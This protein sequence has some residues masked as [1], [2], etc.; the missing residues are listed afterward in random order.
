[1]KTL[2]RLVSKSWITKRLFGMS[3]SKMTPISAEETPEDF[4]I[5]EESSSDF[6]WVPLLKQ[7]CSFPSE[8]FRSVMLNFIH[9]PNFNTNHLFR[10]DISLDVP[11]QYESSEYETEIPPRIAHVKD[12]QLQTV[13]VRTM[14][15]R[16]PLLDKPLDQTCL[17]YESKLECNEIS[18]LVVY[19]SHI[20]SA[21][22]CPHYHPPVRG[23]GFMQRYD[24]KTQQGTISI[25]FSFF[26]SE[27]RSPKLERTAE[28]L[29]A[30]LHKHGKANAAGYTKRVLHDVIIPQARTQNTYARLKAKY[31][32]VLC[33]T[34]VETTDPTKH[35]FED[36]AIAAFLIELWADVYEN[37]IFSGFVDI[38]CGNGLLVHI[39]VEEGYEGWGFDARRRK[40]WTIWSQKSQDNLKEMV[41][42]PSVLQTNHTTAS[43]INA[44][45][46]GGPTNK[47]E[48]HDGVFP[49]G[50]FIISNHADELTPWTPILANI[51]K[52][53]FI[54]IPCCSHALSGAKFRAP[55][56]KGAGATVSQF[57]SLVT[58]V[59]EIAR[60]CGWHVEKEML[61]I[62]STRN[63]AVIG[64]TRVVPYEDVDVK[65]LV[66][67][68][69]GGTGWEE[70]SLKLLK[71]STRGH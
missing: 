56:P 60:S 44:N 3:S 24:P 59:S 52:S 61:R 9:N 17:L 31:A 50:T 20:S 30:V 2:Q 7:D 55:A 49:P 64:R 51:S 32:R 65:D 54:M 63:A 69:G 15:P 23:V 62:P 11:F 28:R 70:N 6:S 21:E 43:E 36:L 37:Q 71:G 26:E 39:L 8:I 53:P 27:P 5:I 46:D 58:W 42:I 10:A 48:I 34:W 66:T 14:I 33:Q 47:P 67:S 38:G 35:V 57:A 19:L 16:N 12:F 29:L 41:L 22:E 25:H 4:S 68:F 13:M 18:S 1:M 40:S 45:A